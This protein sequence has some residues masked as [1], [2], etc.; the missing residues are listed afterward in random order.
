MRKF[1]FLLLLFVVF[2]TCVSC[3]KK[4]SD[5]VVDFSSHPA[6]GYSDISIDEYLVS[7]G[8]FSEDIEE[9]LDSDIYRENFSWNDN[10]FYHWYNT[11]SML[12]VLTYDGDNLV[13]KIECSIKPTNNII[14]VTQNSNGDYIVLSG[15]SLFTIVDGEI[16]QYVGVITNSFIDLITYDNSIVVVEQNEITVYDENLNL[17]NELVSDERIGG[18]CIWDSNLVFVTEKENN[19]LGISELDYDDYSLKEIVNIKCNS[20]ENNSVF[21]DDAFSVG[22]YP[23][24][25]DNVYVFTRNAIIQVDLKAKSGTVVVNTKDFGCGYSLGSDL[26]CMDDDSLCIFSKVIN[27]TN[28]TY[29]ERIVKYTISDILLEKRE[30]VAGM[31]VDYSYFFQEYNRQHMDSYI[32]LV[33]PEEKCDNIQE[34]I[35]LINDEYDVDIWVLNNDYLNKMK[36]SNMLFDLEKLNIG[37]KDLYGNIFDLSKE[38]EERYYIF[39]E[40]KLWYYVS[41]E[42]Q[43]SVVSSQSK[44]LFFNQSQESF[45]YVLYGIIDKDIRDNNVLSE[46]AIS[47]YLEICSRY[48]TDYLDE[49]EFAEEILS[50]NVQFSSQIVSSFEQQFIYS[51]LL[52][53]GLTYCAPMG[54]DSA[55]AI[56][57]TYIAVN[58][59]TTNISDCE[60]II[61]YCLSEEVQKNVSFIPI[62][63]VA[64]KEKGEEYFESLD[65]EQMLSSLQT[66]KP[67][68]NNERELFNNNVQKFIEE[69]NSTSCFYDV[70]MLNELLDKYGFGVEFNEKNID[71]CYEDLDEM[72]STIDSCV[73]YDRLLIEIVQEET[74]IFLKEHKNIAET[75]T[76]ICDRVNIYLS[77]T[78]S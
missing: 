7:H 75:T 65:F 27:S 72:L 48:S 57:D 71:I 59:S 5:I 45:P 42:N 52:C 34:Y 74:Y 40:Y 41:T 33:F 64:V 60:E 43:F 56:C 2:I 36:Q 26:V 30:I 44:G 13:S 21:F 38:E 20:N 50:G 4:S 78:E 49:S 28:G 73:V 6:T 24:D 22:L 3:N 35:D 69:I 18:C 9:I 39:P 76:I 67:L 1:K 12:C 77:E 16:Y 63:K 51:Q 19:T 17:Q 66:Y 68:S 15:D 61:N 46:E 47:E 14:C 31:F 54:Y 55:V 58:S 23:C 37:T 29:D 25:K 53:D 70:E 8:L 62:N 10:L 11:Q 32:S